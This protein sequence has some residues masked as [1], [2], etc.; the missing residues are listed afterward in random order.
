MLVNYDNVMKDVHSIINKPTVL[1][2]WSAE[3]V[4]HFRNL[5]S[6][7]A[8]LK[9]KYPE[10]DFKGINTD[11]H[12]KKWKEVVYKS[13]YN[14]H[15]EYQLDNVK[16]AEQKLLINSMN[17]AI[18]VDKDGIILDGHSNLFSPTIEENLLGYLN[19]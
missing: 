12:F 13:G 11:T 16:D 5:H 6:R 18:I 14:T 1:Y 19:L 17:K 15:H 2:F 3:S 7:A 9:S 4:K 10:Y 8:E